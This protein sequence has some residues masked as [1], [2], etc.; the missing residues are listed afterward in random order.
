MSELMLRML[1]DGFSFRSSI[2]LNSITVSRES[3]SCTFESYDLSMDK[4][5]EVLQAYGA[6]KGV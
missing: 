2:A 3:F 4:L 6:Y 5:M 1:L